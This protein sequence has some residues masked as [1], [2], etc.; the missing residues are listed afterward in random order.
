MSHPS[1]RPLANPENLLSQLEPESANLNPLCPG[2]SPSVHLLT[3]ILC[4]DWHLVPHL[5]QLMTH[6]LLFCSTTLIESIY[7]IIIDLKCVLHR[8]EVANLSGN[9]RF[10]VE[11]LLQPSSAS[12][13]AT[14]RSDLS[15]QNSEIPWG[16]HKWICL[17]QHWRQATQ[18]VVFTKLS[19]LQN[20]WPPIVSCFVKQKEGF[21]WDSDAE[22]DEFF[23]D[24]VGTSP[25]IPSALPSANQAGE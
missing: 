2:V 8:V 23:D 6:D 12:M 14:C 13:N 1:P 18:R 20:P 7:D 11:A 15:S 22:N 17:F 24:F 10:T 21:V 3:N 25:V 5:Q 9:H 19:C 4:Q 16:G